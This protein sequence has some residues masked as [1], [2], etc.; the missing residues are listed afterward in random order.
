MADDPRDRAEQRTL[1]MPRREQSNELAPGHR[2]QEFII[3]QV[4]GVGSFSVVYVAQ[5]TKLQRRV[6]LKEYVPS[7][8]AQREAGGQIVPR[9]PRFI[10]LYDKGLQSFI[11]EARL[12]GSF[13]HASLVKV[14][15]F[16][17][18]NNTAYMVMPYYE[19]I[20]LKRWLADLGTPPSERWLRKLANMLMEA[21]SAMHAQRCFHRDVAPDNILMLYD[22]KA[23]QGS[24]GAAVSYL[25]QK[26]KPVLL[27]FGAARRVIGDATQNLT[28]ILKSGY[29]PVEQYEG[30]VNMRQG[31]WTDVYALCAVLYTAAMGKAPVSSVARVV[32][33]DL[34]PARV[35]GAGRY[36][37]VFLAAIDAGL[38]VRP[39]QRPQNMTELRALLD[40]T[41][42]PPMPVRAPPPAPAK[43]PAAEATDLDLDLTPAAAPQRPAW[44][45]PAVAAAMVV[46]LAGV[47]A[48]LMMRR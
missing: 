11:G 5:D 31:A 42:A 28:A 13:D 35:A 46:A 29:S 24:G 7:Q 2:L 23:A 17:A 25:E 37:D 21:L 6:A 10:E 16:W 1:L 3:Q 43:A 34:I 22:R 12:L 45:L 41:E 15:R 30:E 4:L 20:T 14:Y 32:R 36:S 27:D 40:A 26:P 9:L 47:A 8:L 19:G 33:D 44:L 39:D 48:M 18:E 38:A